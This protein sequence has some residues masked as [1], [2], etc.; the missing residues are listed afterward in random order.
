MSNCVYDD[1][2]DNTEKQKKYFYP[3]P[4][5]WALNPERYNSIGIKTGTWHYRVTQMP[6]GQP[7]RQD[8]AVSE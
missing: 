4:E 1:L 2:H 7:E 5:G 8:K 3:E 6:G